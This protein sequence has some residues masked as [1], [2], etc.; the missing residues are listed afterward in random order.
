MWQ[1]CKYKLTSKESKKKHS[2]KQNTIH[3]GKNI[4]SLPVL[5]PL[6]GESLWAVVAATTSPVVCI[7]SSSCLL[8]YSPFGKSKQNHVHERKGVSHTKLTR[9]PI[10]LSRAHAHTYTHLQH[11]IPGT[12]DQ[13]QRHPKSITHNT[14]PSVTLIY[15][16][17]IIVFVSFL[18]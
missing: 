10:L 4:A 13:T 3:N 5:L 8:N 17:F 9:I 2:Q 12:G 16:K 6:R 11:D 15:N 14:T 1:Y 7:N 18:V